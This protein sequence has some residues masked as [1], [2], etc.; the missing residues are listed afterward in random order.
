[1]LSVFPRILNQSVSAA[2]HTISHPTFQELMKSEKFDLFVSGFFFNN[3]QLGLAAHFQCPS[4]VLSSIPNVR[5][6]N[7]LVGQPSN[8]ELIA[9]PISG[10]KKGN[11]N[12]WER[13]MN[14]VATL[15]EWGFNIYVNRVNERYYK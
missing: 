8:Y 2:H 13:V 1:M 6:L 5:A 7:E 14:F 3:F 9:N 11:M 4:V 15:V 10:V 12:L